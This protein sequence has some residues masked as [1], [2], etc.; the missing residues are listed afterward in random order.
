MS[1]GI[2]FRSNSKSGLR[3]PG[4]KHSPLGNSLWKVSSPQKE[5]C[6][7]CPFPTRVWRIINQEQLLRGQNLAWLD[8]HFFP[9]IRQQVIV[10]PENC[11]P[12]SNWMGTWVM[13]LA[14]GISMVSDG[15]KNI[16]GYLSVQRGG[17][18]PMSIT[19]L[20]TSLSPCC[21]CR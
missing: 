14:E 10:I 21:P 15:N 7:Q 5:P 1:E 9:L 13:F 16:H 3:S 19:E 18:T 20:L 12:C 6:L 8:G 2:D 11:D 4:Y 17:L